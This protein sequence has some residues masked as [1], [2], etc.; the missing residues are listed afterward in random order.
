[1]HCASIGSPIVGD[2]LYWDAAAAARESLGS[3]P[4][5]N[6]KKGVGLFLQSI[7]AGFTHPRSG[8]R[9]EIEIPIVDKFARLLE[10]ARGANVFDKEGVGESAK[11]GE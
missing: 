3:P 4:L 9:I 10:K 8:D 5:P 11:S 6:V 1:M 2:D 7:G